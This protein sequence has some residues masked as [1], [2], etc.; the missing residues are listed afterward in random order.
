MAHLNF[1]ILA[2]C[3]QSD[4]GSVLTPLGFP[5]LYKSASEQILP[6]GTARDISD[7][8]FRAM[9]VNVGIEP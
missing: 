9:R 7:Q 5:I 6:V 2:L 3:S 1:I 8:L 4:W